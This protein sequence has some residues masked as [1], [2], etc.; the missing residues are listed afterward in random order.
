[1]VISQ[2]GCTSLQPI[3][4]T[5]PELQQRIAVRALLEPGDR[6]LIVTT[7]G[8]KH[9]FTVTAAGPNGIEGKNES[10]A[11]DQI[12]SVQ[13]RRFSVARTVWLG[14]AVGVVVVWGIVAAARAS[15]PVSFYGGN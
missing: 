5:P 14:V 10:V 1:M 13:K 15:P 2:A 12:A 3:A 7:D 4:G 6:V 11:V 8:T 9:E